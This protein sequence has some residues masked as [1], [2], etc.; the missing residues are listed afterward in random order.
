MRE[1]W[2][3]VDVYKRRGVCGDNPYG[4]HEVVDFYGLRVERR[5]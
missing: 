4:G 5:L 3:E 1:G 2:C